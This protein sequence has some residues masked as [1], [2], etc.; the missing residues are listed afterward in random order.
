MSPA[1][2]AITGLRPV[3][4][5]ASEPTLDASSA[6]STVRR[7]N[8]IDVNFLS[9]TASEKLGYHSSAWPEADATE[10]KPYEHTCA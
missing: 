8:S 5:A 1:L 7:V 10:P 9:I 6:S 2:V 4:A 3:V